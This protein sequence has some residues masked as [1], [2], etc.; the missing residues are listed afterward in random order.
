MWCI[1]TRQSNSRLELRTPR[2]SRLKTQHPT[3]H[4]GGYVEHG[5]RSDG[6][7]KRRRSFGE[8]RQTH[9]PTDSGGGGSPCATP[10]AGRPFVREQFSA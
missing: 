9:D 8:S 4:A 3:T 1:Q 2:A 5:H 6:S 7:A 10:G